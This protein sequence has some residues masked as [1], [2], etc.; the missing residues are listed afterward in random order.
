MAFMAAGEVVAQGSPSQIKASQPGQLFELDV[1]QPQTASDLLKQTFDP[2]R[3]SVFGD[4][5][6]IVLDQPDS[7]VPRL[8]SL[9][10][11]AALDLQ[12][13]QP[14]PFSLEDAFIGIVQRAQGGQP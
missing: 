2:W 13:C 14:L 8:H 3:A 5:L 12:D 7:E 11:T 4:R 1:A 6:H 10:Q 9:L